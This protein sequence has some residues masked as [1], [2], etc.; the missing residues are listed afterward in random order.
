MSTNLVCIMCDENEHCLDTDIP[1]PDRLNIINVGNY[2]PAGLFSGYPKKGFA[3]CKLMEQAF[4][5]DLKPVLNEDFTAFMWSYQRQQRLGKIAYP[6]DPK[7]LDKFDIKY[8]IILDN[9]LSSV[10]DPAD[11]LRRYILIGQ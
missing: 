1:V 2:I 7:K 8:G 6:V 3:S 10:I 9:E 11:R 4:D 5:D